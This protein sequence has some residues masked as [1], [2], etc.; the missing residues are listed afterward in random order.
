MVA[1][2]DFQTKLTSDQL[3][4]VDEYWKIM[5][6]TSRNEFVRLAIRYYIEMHR[7]PKKVKP[8]QKIDPNEPFTQVS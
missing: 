7:P 4:E 2:S 1:I 5:Q 6:F 3:V 8:P